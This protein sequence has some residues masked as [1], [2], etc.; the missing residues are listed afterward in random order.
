VVWTDALTAADTYRA[1]AYKVEPVPN[2]PGEFFAYVAYDLDLFEPAAHLDAVGAATHRATSPGARSRRE[3]RGV[4][5]AGCQSA[6]CMTRT[7]AVDPE[8]ALDGIGART[9]FVDALG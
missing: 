9:Y 4:V 2:A 1:K 6:R 3:N 8:H 5:P 7:N